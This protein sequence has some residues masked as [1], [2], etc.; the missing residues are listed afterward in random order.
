MRMTITTPEHE[1]G[2]V[3]VSIFE[4]TKHYDDTDDLFTNSLP[5]TEVIAEFKLTKRQ[6]YNLQRYLAEA[7]NSNAYMLAYDLE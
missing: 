1:H 5:T 2:N 4:V 3:L 6:A 7:S